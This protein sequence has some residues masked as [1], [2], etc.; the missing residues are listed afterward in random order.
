METSCQ[1]S[2]ISPNAWLGVMIS[3]N[4]LFPYDPHKTHVSFKWTNNLVL[5]EKIRIFFGVLNDAYN[6][7]SMKIKIKKNNFKGNIL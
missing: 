2:Y 4:V 7:I 6:H 3:S 5:T 1:I